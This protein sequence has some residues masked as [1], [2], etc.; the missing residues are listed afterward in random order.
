METMKSADSLYVVKVSSAKMPNSCWG[1]Y[2]HV[3]VLEV[4]ADAPRIHAIDI[5]PHYVRRIVRVWRN[6]NVGKTPRCASERAECAA[7]ELAAELS[8]RRAART[9]T[10]ARDMH[11]VE[12]S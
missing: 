4:D 6:C 10:E 5:R 3:A 9:M 2:V 7:Y 12:G 1:R 11:R 8:D